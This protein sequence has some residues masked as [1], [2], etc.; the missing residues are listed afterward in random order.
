MTEKKH[1]LGNVTCAEAYLALFAQEN[2]TI[3]IAPL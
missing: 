3:T 1:R 2:K